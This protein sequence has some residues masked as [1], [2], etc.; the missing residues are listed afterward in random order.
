M[1]SLIRP[2]YLSTY[3]STFW[4]DSELQSGTVASGTEEG[5]ILSGDG[6][7]Y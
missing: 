5:E 4:T 2:R 6:R 7:S 1:L 3:T